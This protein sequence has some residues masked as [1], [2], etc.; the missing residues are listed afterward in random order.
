MG[1][2]QDL[3]DAK[4]VL[5]SGSSCLCVSAAAGEFVLAFPSV[6][7]LVCTCVSMLQAQLGGPECPRLLTPSLMSSM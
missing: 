7:G 6:H 1:E 3:K 2:R 4:N 5:V